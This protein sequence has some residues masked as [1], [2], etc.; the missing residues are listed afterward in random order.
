MSSESANISNIPDATIKTWY[1]DGEKRWLV[2]ERETNWEQIDLI[3]S[4][5]TRIPCSIPTN[6]NEGADSNEKSGGRDGSEIIV[7]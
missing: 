3:L 5:I 2:L 1:K 7:R 6:G 4:P